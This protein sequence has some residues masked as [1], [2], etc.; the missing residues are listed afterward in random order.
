[1][2]SMKDW[3]SSGQRSPLF[4]DQPQKLKLCVSDV[5]FGTEVNNLFI[6][7]VSLLLP[8]TP[9]PVSNKVGISNQY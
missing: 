4:L 5:T 8:P 6:F 7:F 2:F 1:M 9:H 3:S